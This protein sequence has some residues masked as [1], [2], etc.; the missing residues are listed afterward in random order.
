MKRIFQLLC[1]GFLLSQMACSGT[2]SLSGEGSNPAEALF[3]KGTVTWSALY[4]GYKTDFHVVSLALAAD[5]KEYKGV[6]TYVDSKTQFQLNGPVHESP[7]TVEAIVHPA[8][9]TGTI[10][11]TDEMG[12]LNLT[13]SGEKVRIGPDH[14][15]YL[16]L[17]ENY[18]GERTGMFRCLLSKGQ[19]DMYYEASQNP[20]GFE[21]HLKKVSS[22]TGKVPFTQQTSGKSWK[23]EDGQYE[24]TLTE[25][26]ANPTVYFY[27]KE[28]KMVLENDWFIELDRSPI[29]MSTG[30]MDTDQNRMAYL[31]ANERKSGERS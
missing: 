21:V 3:P 12:G 23:S 28:R 4:Q 16:T 25:A 11:T 14:P 17:D 26:Q 6:L 5:D 15:A 7:K 8:E 29:F 30:L 9:V 27:D 24:L 2:R 13:I 18:Q 1:I 10:S 22:L 20:V 19:L 31:L